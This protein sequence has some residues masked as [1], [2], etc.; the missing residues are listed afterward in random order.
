MYTL[1]KETTIWSD[2]RMHN[3]VYVFEDKPKGRQGKAIGFINHL[4]D[5][6]KYFNKPLSMDFK[7]R[8][9]VEVGKLKFDLVKP[10]H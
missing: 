10:I 2:S 4:S 1:L 7:D 9:F 5:E 3:H 8:T 6:V